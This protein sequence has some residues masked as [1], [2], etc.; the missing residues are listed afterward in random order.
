MPPGDSL[1]EYVFPSHLTPARQAKVAR[2]V[3]NK[4]SIH[5]LFNEKHVTAL[6]DTGAQVSIMSEEFPHKQ[7]RT[8]DIKDIR[9][10]LSVNGTVNL[11]AANGSPI[12]YIGWVDI[13]VKLEGTD[14]HEVVVPFLITPNNIGPPIIGYNVIE[15]LVKEAMEMW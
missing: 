13:K 10:L 2:L 15:L 7:L 9:K 14:K 3:G 8:V 1:D 4:C 12:P 5:C 6:W 11:Q